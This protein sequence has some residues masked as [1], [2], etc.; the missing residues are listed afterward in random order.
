MAAVD[1]DTE[2][3]WLS[4]FFLNRK[5]IR[6]LP[7]VARASASVIA[8][9][10]MLVFAALV[11]LSLFLLARLIW[12]ALTLPSTVYQ[13]SAKN[14]FF[15]LVGVFGA[16][17][18]VWRTW[19]AH[20]QA[21]A[22]ARQANVAF[23]NQIT[24][25]FTKSVELLGGIRELKTIRPDGTSI[26]RSMPNYEARLGALYSLERLL[27]ESKSD[28]RAILETLCAYVR[29]NSPLELPEEDKERQEFFFGARTPKATRRSDVQ[30]ALT[31]I[32]RRSLQVRQEAE[33]GVWNLD[34]RDTNLVGYDLSGLNFDRSDFTGSFLNASKLNESSFARSVFDRS[35]LRN[36]N[37]EDTSFR[38]SCFKH[39]NLGG[40]QI[41]N[42]DFRDTKLERTD[43]CGAN[44]TSLDISGANL[45]S[46]FSSILRYIVDRIRSQGTAEPWEM[47]EIA[48]VATF[49]AKATYN[50]QTILSEDVRDVISLTRGYG[51]VD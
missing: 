33:H 45:E 38:F 27:N 22:A 39:A 32:G 42:T 19:V 10:A 11:L 35:V 29:E 41:V 1:S 14:F 30:A 9:I 21:A 31:I 24:G 7:S 3:D 20:M 46:A 48:S 23:E 25:I 18:L 51:N 43:L 16:P 44:L 36:A 47:T 5:A 28:R 50:D 6:A 49:L 17:F 12:D 13:D 15:A 34:F 26:T 4:D 8:I 2:T 37:L 40:A